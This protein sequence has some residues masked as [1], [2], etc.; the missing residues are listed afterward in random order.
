MFV[1]P[2]VIHNSI[3]G[4]VFHPSGRK[5]F[6]DTAKISLISTAW[7]DNPRKGGPFY[8]WLDEHLDFSRFEYTFVGRVKQEFKNIKHIVP[9][10]SGNLAELLRQHDIYISASLHEPCSN[11]LLEALACGLPS[12]YR[13]D[14]GSSELVEFGGLPFNDED[15]FLPQLDRVA[16][17]YESFQLSIYIKSMDDI[18]GKYLQLAQ[19]VVQHH[20]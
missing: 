5:K 19:K 3:D 15:D 13:N 10:D 20:N 18:V 11:A 8:K 9:Q 1:S 16:A 17:H 6:D 7:S 4:D 12:L 2:V 14:G